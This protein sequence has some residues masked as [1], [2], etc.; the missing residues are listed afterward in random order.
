M[1]QR[2]TFYEIFATILILSYYMMSAYAKEPLNFKGH[3]FFLQEFSGYKS[4]YVFSAVLRQNLVFR[5]E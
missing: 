1:Y 5:T 3:N 4:G 2:Y